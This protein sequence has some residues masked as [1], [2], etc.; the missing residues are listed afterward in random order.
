MPIRC[1]F[2]FTDDM[3]ELELQ[4]KANRARCL[5]H[6]GLAAFLAICVRFSCDS[7][8]ALAW[9]P[10]RPPFRPIVDRY[11]LTDWVGSS[12][13]SRTISAAS[14]LG[15]AGSFLLE[16]LIHEVSHDIEIRGLLQSVA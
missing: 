10:L 3:T 2:D 8:F 14:W 4:S 1:I 13:D 12:V 15:S 7:F 16:R 9:P 6:L 5:A 11:S